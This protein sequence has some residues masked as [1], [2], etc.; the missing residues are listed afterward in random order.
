MLF[1]YHKKPF[2]AICFIGLLL[3]IGS[4]WGTATL[5]VIGLGMWALATLLF[6]RRKW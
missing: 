3:M 1:G 6:G 2:Y 4:V 5:F